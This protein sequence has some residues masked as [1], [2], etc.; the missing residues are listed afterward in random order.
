MLS[1]QSIKLLKWLNEKDEWMFEFQLE[2]SFPSYDDRLL[3]ALVRDNFVDHGVPADPCPEY[4]EY[5]NV[6]YPEEYRINDRGRAY[7]ELMVKNRWKELR[8]WVTLAI[9]CAS[10]VLAVISL[11]LQQ[12]TGQV[13]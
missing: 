4:D 13:P 7:L 11:L 10:F 12:P 1:R 8:A 5:N 6:Y 9:A 3:K 2:K